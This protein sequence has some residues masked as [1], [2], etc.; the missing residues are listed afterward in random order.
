VNIYFCRVIAENYQG[1]STCQDYIEI[2]TERIKKNNM[3]DSRWK[4][5]EVGAHLA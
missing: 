1:W 4:P 5:L 3:E 2:K